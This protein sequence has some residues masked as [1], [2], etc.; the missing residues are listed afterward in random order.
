MT[1]RGHVEEVRERIIR[2][3]MKVFAVQGYFRAPTGIIAREAGVSKGLLFWYFRSKDELILEVATRSLPVDVLDTCLS[4]GLKGREVLECVGEGFMEKYSND[5]MRSLLLQT[6]A[7]R[8]VYPQ[9]RE[10]FKRV[11][12]DYIARLA[13]AAFGGRD[14][15]RRV[16]V[17]AFLGA[18]VCYILGPPPDMPWRDYLGHLI[19]SLWEASQAG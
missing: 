8:D 11:C 15:A 14:P 9:L 1:R 10:A 7:A 13:E 6:M 18:L 3:A 16:R 4:R 5:V 19:D 2:A 17:R 12:L